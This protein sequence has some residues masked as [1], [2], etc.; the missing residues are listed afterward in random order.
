MFDVWVIASAVLKFALYLGA[1]IPTG[2]ILCRLLLGIRDEV[3]PIRR[4]ILWGAALGLIAAVL[5]FAIRGTALTGDLSGAFDGEILGILWSTPV[6]DALAWR[7]AGFALILL[8]ALLGSRFDLGGLLGGAVVLWSFAAIGHVTDANA[9][10]IRIA[11]IVHLFCIAF[12]IGVLAPLRRLALNTQDIQTAADIG[13]RFGQ[14]AMLAIPGLILAGVLMSFRLIGG[15]AGFLTPYG[16][17][18][19]LK[20]G[21]VAGL[22]ALG[23]ANKLRFVPRMRSGD[24][25][26]AQHLAASIRWEWLC[27]LIILATTAWLTS[28]LSPPA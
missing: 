6:G 23:A 28:A 24:A 19:L 3:F 21:V 11:L 14:I 22:L 26:A 7:V 10:W 1:L 16:L 12:W 27:V 2:L 9:M 18:L 15:T 20:V 25:Y 13:H 5:G 17:V 8:C 4:W